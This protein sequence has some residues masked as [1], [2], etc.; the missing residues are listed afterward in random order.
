M[1]CYFDIQKVFIL[2]LISPPFNRRAYQSYKYLFFTVFGLKI[3][4]N[5]FDGQ[6][7]ITYLIGWQVFDKY[8]Y[9]DRWIA[10]MQKTVLPIC[11]ICGADDLNSGRHMAKRYEELIPKPI[12]YY[13]ENGIGH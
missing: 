13:L 10:A 9:Q 4:C 3:G 11:Y 7:S 12:V 5:R 2:S 1:F 8:K 6:R